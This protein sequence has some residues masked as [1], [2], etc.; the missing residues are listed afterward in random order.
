[1]LAKEHV[2]MKEKNIHLFHPSN[3]LNIKVI[4]PWNSNL[5]STKDTQLYGR[6][7]KLEESSKDQCLRMLWFYKNVGKSNFFCGHNIL[8]EGV[9]ES[10][11]SSNACIAVWWN[12]WVTTNCRFVSGTTSL[13]VSFGH[14][15]SCLMQ[16]K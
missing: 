16:T 14:E 7:D 6:H 3:N 5:S 13:G 12:V 1:M 4:L 2:I 8:I 11:L 15:T 9:F 10:Q